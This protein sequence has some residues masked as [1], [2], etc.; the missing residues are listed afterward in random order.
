MSEEEKRER[1]V[2]LCRCGC[3]NPVTAK[4][5][6][7]VFGHCRRGA[8]LS[9][10]SR[11]KMSQARLLSQPVECSCKQCGFPLARPPSSAPAAIC[12]KCKAVEQR[13]RSQKWYLANS[14][15]AK[16]RTLAAK[17]ESEKKLWAIRLKEDFHCACGAKLEP[18]KT[19]LG[20]AF[21]KCLGCKTKTAKERTARGREKARGRY[22]I[23]KHLYAPAKAK[24]RK[25]NRDKINSTA[26]RWWLR[27]RAAYMKSVKYAIHRLA[28]E[29]GVSSKNIPE[30]VARV[31]LLVLELKRELRK[32]KQ[33]EDHE[34]NPGPVVRGDR[35]AAG[36]EDHGGEC[37]RRGECDGQNPDHHQDGNG[38]CQVSGQVG[39]HEVHRVGG[40]EGGGRAQDEASGEAMSNVEHANT[41]EDRCYK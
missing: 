34:P 5:N 25:D 1:V 3:G 2:A 21:R 27:H 7:Y 16:A 36:E 37:E 15:K 33:N 29:T 20:W 30:S 23:R 38:V 32:A 6:V 10:K 14:A 22:Q 4:R 17:R 11:D 24:W 35:R 8:K 28:N 26:R 12:V 39:E 13:K 31:K 40:C 41:E 19:R 9:R 18:P